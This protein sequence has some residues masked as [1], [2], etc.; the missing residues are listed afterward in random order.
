ML[1][2]N[3]IEKDLENHLG[4]T[5]AGAIPASMQLPYFYTAPGIA[6]VNVTLEI[7]S[8]PLKFEK[9]KGGALESDVNVLG[10]A[11]TAD[12]TV[13]ARFSDTLKLDFHDKKQVDEFKQKPL[14]YENQFDVAAGKYTLKVVFSTGG[15]SFGKVEMP[16]EIDPY[17]SNQFAMSGLALSKQYLRVSDAGSGLDAALIEDKTPLIANGVEVIPAGTA[18]FHKGEPALFYFEIYEPLLLNPDPAN[19]PG[20]AIRMRI[21]D[22]KTGEAK[23]DTG[24]LRID[25]PKENGTPV[26]RTAERMPVE[27]LQP[28]SYV[29]ELAAQDTASQFARRTAD[30]DLQ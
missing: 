1:S 17:Q 25:L 23:Q 12:G 3:P 14:H 9:E 22:R 19:P 30:F 6:R 2:G 15:A 24:L 27:Q 4:G 5:Q 16:L 13:G 8:E 29:L 11:Y 28:G 26:V 18:Q 10:I 21:L 7:A 20:V